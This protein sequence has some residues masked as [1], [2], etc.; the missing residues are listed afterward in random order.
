MLKP[1]FS[2]TYKIKWGI[3][4]HRKEIT[5]GSQFQRQIQKA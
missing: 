4:P 5:S 3:Q 1:N 2:M